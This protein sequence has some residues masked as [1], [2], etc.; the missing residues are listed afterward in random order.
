MT[1]EP[2]VAT[3]IARVEAATGPSRE[4]DAEIAALVRAV[5]ANAPGWLM[6]WSGFK[7]APEFPPGAI[8]AYGGNGKITAWWNAPLYTSSIDAD[9]TLL[10]DW[11]WRVGNLPSGRTFADLG[12]QKSM[13]G[14]EGSTPAIA[15]CIV[16]L[17]VRA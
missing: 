12:T 11:S 5:P 1:T 17:K 6:R 2:D 10:P 15:L 7:V 9:L 3:L 16:A 13:W 14:I 8:A 4:L